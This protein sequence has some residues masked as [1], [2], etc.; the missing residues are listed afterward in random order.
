M[1]FFLVSL[2][3]YFLQKAKDY[4]TSVGSVLFEVVFEVV[5][6]IYVLLDKFC[7]NKQGN[8][9]TCKSFLNLNKTKNRNQDRLKKDEWVKATSLINRA[10]PGITWII[11]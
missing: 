6:C 9:A 11:D 3:I 1:N 2:R 8:Q 5:L 4:P 10:W 7:S